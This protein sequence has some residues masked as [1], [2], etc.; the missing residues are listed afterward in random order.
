[1]RMAKAMAVL[2]QGCNLHACQDMM[3]GMRGQAG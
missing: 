1:M 2:G 3:A